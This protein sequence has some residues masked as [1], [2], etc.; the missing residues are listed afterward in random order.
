MW[1]WGRLLFFKGGLITKKKKEGFAKKD[2]N[3][4][5][6]VLAMIFFLTEQAALG[7]VFL[8]ASLTSLKGEK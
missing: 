2:V 5:M 8:V 4:G 6:L 1:E 3:T 7:A